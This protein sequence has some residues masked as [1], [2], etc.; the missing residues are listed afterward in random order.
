LGNIS[1]KRF[2]INDINDCLPQET[3]D[4]MINAFKYELKAHT[5]I[6]FNKLYGNNFKYFMNDGNIV[7][8]HNKNIYWYYI[9]SD[10]LTELQVY[11]FSYG[12]RCKVIGKNKNNIIYKHYLTDNKEISIW[13]YKFKFMKSFNIEQEG[14][15]L[16]TK[17]KESII[18]RIYNT[19]IK[20]NGEFK[21]FNKIIKRIK[22]FKKDIDYYMSFRYFYD[23]E[24]SLIFINARNKMNYGVG[25]VLNSPLGSKY[26]NNVT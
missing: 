19:Y 1:L 26:G 6:T 21:I 16:N 3:F 17:I 23:D 20:T 15:R 5:L 2:K 4:Y 25:L 8:L 22:Y 10:Y 18:Y 9:N 13:N 24:K 7:I 12:L 11:K 14:D